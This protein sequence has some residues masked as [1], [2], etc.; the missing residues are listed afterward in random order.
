M[1]CR[2]QTRGSTIQFAN[3][4][5]FWSS[6]FSYVQ[7]IDLGNDMVCPSCGPNPDSTI[8]DGIIVSFSWKNLMPT[9]WPPITIGN[10]SMSRSNVCPVPNLQPIP[11]WNIQ[12]LVCHV[13]VGPRLTTIPEG[14]Q[15]QGSLEYKQNRKMVER[16]SQ[17][18]DLVAKLSEINSSLGGL[19]NSHFGIATIFGKKNMPE[20]YS[21][22]FIQ[23]QS[24]FS[25]CVH[26]EAIPTACFGWECFT[27]GHRS[28]HSSYAK[29]HLAS[30]A[31]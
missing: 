28:G 6:W 20:V 25:Q 5:L 29:F 12:L 11:N 23:V 10:T 3:E 18:P 22:L 4:K 1:S 14:T 16:L 26:S 24:L 30:I 13:L 19:F 27:I 8:W 31:E 2:Y 17:I 9:L 15:L 7:L 21:R